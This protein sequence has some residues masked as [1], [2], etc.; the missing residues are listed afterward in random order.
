MQ[1]YLEI[2]QPRLFQNSLG[3]NRNHPRV[4]TYKLAEITVC[5]KCQMARRFVNR[6]HSI[7]NSWIGLLTIM[8]NSSYFDTLHVQINMLFFPLTMSQRSLNSSSISWGIC[9]ICLDFMGQRKAN[10]SCFNKLL[11]KD[12]LSVPLNNVY[13]PKKTRS[14]IFLYKH[15]FINCFLSFN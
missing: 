9:I 14:P 8:K 2:I 12:S 4:W 15:P 3:Q 6:P 7:E 11:C 1:S 13:L 10:N 5:T